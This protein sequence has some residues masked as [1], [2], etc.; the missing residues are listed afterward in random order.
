ML[1]HQILHKSLTFAEATLAQQRE[2]EQMRTTCPAHQ[3]PA[4]LEPHSL[5]RLEKCNHVKHNKI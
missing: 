1:I 2:I 3:C 5:M 4:Q